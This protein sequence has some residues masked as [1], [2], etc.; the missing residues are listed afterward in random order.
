MQ[1]RGEGV[2]KAENF[3][4][5]LSGSS[6]TTL[7]NPAFIGLNQLIRGIGWSQVSDEETNQR[8]KSSHK[9]AIKH[10]FG[11]SKGFWSRGEEEEEEG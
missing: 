6:L 3:A 9:K 8:T 10:E 5:I 7:G 1:T 2:K 4:D 11:E